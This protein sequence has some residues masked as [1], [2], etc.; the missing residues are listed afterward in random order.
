MSPMFK[1]AV[2]CVVIEVLIVVLAPL[3]NFFTPKGQHHW[4][5]FIIIAIGVVG[6]VSGAIG[7]IIVVL[8]M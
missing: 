8:A 3:I 1:V 7:A 6:V 5:G 4:L 2:T